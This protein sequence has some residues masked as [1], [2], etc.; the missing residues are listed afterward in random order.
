MEVETAEQISQCSDERR[1][2]KFTTDFGDG[3]TEEVKRQLLT[4]HENMQH[5]INP[6]ERLFRL[7]PGIRV[8]WESLDD[9]TF[10][11]SGQSSQNT[12]NMQ[13][14]ER[15]RDVNIRDHNNHKTTARFKSLENLKIDQPASGSYKIWKRPYSANVNMCEMMSSSIPFLLKFFW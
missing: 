10:W 15:E 4:L 7:L 5:P 11:L 1:H 9:S 14:K 8:C 3:D 12:T 2:P 6:Q 13:W